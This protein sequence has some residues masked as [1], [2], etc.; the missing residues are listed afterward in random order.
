MFALR[1]NP[2]ASQVVLSLIFGLGLGGGYA[3]SADRPGQAG[4]V[5]S[6]FV[7]DEPPTPS[8]HASSVLE[9]RPGILLATWFAGTAERMPDVVIYT[10]RMENGRWSKPVVVADGVRAETRHPCWNPVLCRTGDGA[11][12]LFFKV[13]PTPRTWWGEVISSNDEG[14]SWSKPRRLPE[15]VLGPIKNKPLSLPD[16]ILLCP[17]SSEDEQLGWRVF[18]EC[19]PDSGQTWSRIGPLNDGKRLAAIQPSILTHPGGQLQ[20]LCRTRQGKIAEA[21]ST[22][23]G[24]TWGPMT[25]TDLPNPNSGTDAV[26]LA[27]GRQLLV[28]NHTSEKRRTP[29]NVAISSDGKS[30]RPSVVL[31]DEPGEYSYPAVIQAKDGKVHITY[32]W[33]RKKI[34]HIVLDPSGLDSKPTEARP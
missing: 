11:I 16:G 10:S 14:Q 24:A 29:L 23:H 6:E 12:L 22:D 8:C 2:A 32:T 31:E 13:G 33:Q 30:W 21:W 4:V 18:L 26:T 25:L 34:K 27:D 17:S 5:S 20:I 15:G 28:Y 1:H 3:T 19:T 9:V 7:F